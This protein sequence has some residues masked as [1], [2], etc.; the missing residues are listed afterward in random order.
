MPASLKVQVAKNKRIMNFFT[1]LDSPPI[2]NNLI[3]LPSS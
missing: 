1:N 3:M 2:T